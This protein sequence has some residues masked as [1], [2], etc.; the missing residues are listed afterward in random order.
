[1]Y[2]KI[3]DKSSALHG[4]VPVLILLFMIRINIEGRYIII[5]NESYIRPQLILSIPLLMVYVNISQYFL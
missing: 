3:I 5:P 1:M 2:K 4:N